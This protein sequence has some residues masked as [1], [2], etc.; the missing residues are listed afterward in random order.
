MLE[1]DMVSSSDGDTAGVLELH[2]DVLL[3]S[4]L[5]KKKLYF[6]DESFY[7]M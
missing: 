6:I 3:F 1:E 5:C 4:A 7:F 2:T